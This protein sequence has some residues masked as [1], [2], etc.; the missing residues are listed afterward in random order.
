[1]S[2]DKLIE[3]LELTAELALKLIEDVRKLQE[4]IL[5]LI[6]KYKDERKEQDEKLRF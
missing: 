4:D 5:N 2:I 3:K 1:M 6:D